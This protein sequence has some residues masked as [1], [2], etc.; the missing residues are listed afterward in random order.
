MS[1]YTNRIWIW[2]ELMYAGNFIPVMRMRTSYFN[3]YSIYAELW[4]LAF[5]VS[6][7]NLFTLFKNAADP[8]I[9][10][11]AHDHDVE[12]RNATINLVVIYFKLTGNWWIWVTSCKWLWLPF[13]TFLLYLSL[14]W[15]FNYLLVREGSE[16]ATEKYAYLSMV[17]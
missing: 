13:S 15:F 7:E 14:W 10:S 6:N 3:R 1:F 5:R 4:R 2:L 17:W 9:S 8:I 11:F 12:E 16:W